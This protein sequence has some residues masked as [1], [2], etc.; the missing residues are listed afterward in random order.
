MV[1]ILALL[2]LSSPHD[3]FN[4]FFYIL[5][6]EAVLTLPTRT[7]TAWI[8]AFFL[9]DSLNAIW[10]QGSTGLTGVLFYAAAFTLAALFG[11]ALR[12]AEI[13][14]HENEELLE[15]LKS[16]Q[17]QLLNVAV[18]EER[19]RMAREMHDSLGHRLTVS[20]VQLEGAQRLIPTEPERAARMI[21]MMRDEM[22]EALAELRRTVS[23]LRAPIADDPSLNTALLT[24]SQTFQQNTGIPTHFSVSPDFPELPA[25]HRLALYRAA[26]EALTNIQRHAMADNA[27]LE[28]NADDQKVTLV[29]EDDGKGIDLHQVNGASSGLL[30]IRER[31]VQLGGEMRLVDRQGGGTQLIFTLPLPKQ[32]VNI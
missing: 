31:A 11:Y 24:L 23:T 15:E 14:R 25:G 16:I 28:L 3:I 12:Q 29:M 20:I 10:N 17:L 1:I 8:A 30:G 32:G 26:Q 5:A 22:K 19:T 27:W 18:N 4:F 7:A 21:G 6:L 2:R 9:I 13:A